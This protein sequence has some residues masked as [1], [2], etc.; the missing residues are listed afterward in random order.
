MNEMHAA[1]TLAILEDHA[2]VRDGYVSMLTADGEFDV[3]YAGASIQA[4]VA[5]RRAPDV[6]LFGRRINGQIVTSDQREDLISRGSRVIVIGELKSAP[7]IESLMSAGVQG[8]VSKRDSSESLVAAIRAVSRGELWMAPEV[9]A[10]LAK[11]RDIKRPNLSSREQEALSLYL[12]GMKVTSVARRMGISPHTARE[13]LDRVRRKYAD[14]GR[15][16]STRTALT[17]EAR[18]DGFEPDDG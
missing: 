4:V 2:L 13:Y 9:A 5:L 12:P 10:T 6:I 1:H 17:R 7:E 15:D 18:R 8:F 14:C 3:I 11:D 16:A